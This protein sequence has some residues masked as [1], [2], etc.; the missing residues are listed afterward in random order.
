[1]NV[2]F[3]PKS[4]QGPSPEENGLAELDRPGFVAW[5]SG[6]WGMDF[7]PGQARNLIYGSPERAMSRGVV[8]DTQG[9]LFLIEK[10]SR[11]AREQKQ[12]IAGGLA[13]LKQNGLDRILVPEVTCDG[14][15]LGEYRGAFFQVTRFVEGTDLPRPGW[16]AS[17][18]R[19]GAMASFLI[20]MRRCAQG[21][22][23]PWPSFS[24][25]AYIYK[26]FEDMKARHPDHHAR[27]LP[28]LRFLESEFMAVHDRL[29]QAFSHGDFHPINVIW[30][31]EKIRA[32]IDWE[33][34]GIKPDIYDAANLLGC[35]GIEHPEGLAMPM[36]TTF[37]SDLYRAFA[38]SAQGWQVLPDYVLALRF[39]WLSEWLRK[40]D[41]Q[42][43]DMELQFME[44][45][46]ANRSDLAAVWADAV[47]A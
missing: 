13:A 26:L 37:L 24:I 18:E 10:F 42:M 38:I 35:A 6:C 46:M 5:A 11:Q 44:I 43:L 14:G 31:D 39:A 28:V 22:G 12:R 36:V 29:P 8:A 21:L 9:R 20:D 4:F 23:M 19:G 34:T 27:Y 32:V 16:L 45:L 3:D 2:S 25:K 7:S 33:F 40:E 15:P 30:K 17:R 41:Q 47:G 1:M